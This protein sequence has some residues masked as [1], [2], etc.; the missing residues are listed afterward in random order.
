MTNIKFAVFTDLHHDNIPD[1]E[2]RIDELVQKLKHENLDFLIQ[3]GDFAHPLSKN[4]VLIDKINELEIPF[5]SVIGNH[6]TDISSR[7]EVMKFLNLDKSYYSFKYGNT[8]FIVLD[9]CYVKSNEVEIEY[10]K[11][12]YNKINDTYPIIPK[13]MIEW[14]RVELN[15][16][17]E[18]ICL[19]SHHSLI[20]EFPSRGIFNRKEIMALISNAKLNGKKILFYMNG[21]DHGEDIEKINDTYYFGLNSISNI[22][23][24]PQYEA[25]LYGEDIHAK[26]PMLKDLILYEDPLHAVIT[27]SSN[28]AFQVQG[29]KSNYQLRNP[30][31]LKIGDEWNGRSIL[32]KVSSLHICE[33]GE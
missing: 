20:N 12:D 4:R 26:Y 30:Q 14:L 23:I 7:M 29:M 17:I 5:H 18:N 28:G 1:G 24:G 21:H 9:S 8:K 3:L 2:E 22:W 6:D 13:H 11:K 31:D 32:P 10:Y 27:I 16:D 25:F 33:Q 15:D 19:F